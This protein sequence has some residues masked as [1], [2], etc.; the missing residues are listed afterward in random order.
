[1]RGSRKFFFSEGVQLCQCFFFS[2]FGEE[3]RIY[4]QKR[5]TIGPGGETPFKWRFAGG[6]IV[7]QHNTLNARLKDLLFYRG[8]VPVL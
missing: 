8:S 6:P 3:E 7:A 5:A 4:R 1:M 2:R